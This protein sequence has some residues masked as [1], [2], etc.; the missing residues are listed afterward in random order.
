[1]VVP[2]ISFRV[3]NTV[4]PFPEME[5]EAGGHWSQDLV[6]WSEKRSAWNCQEIEMERAYRRA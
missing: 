3:G 1:M 6:T 2:L 5:Q 4:I